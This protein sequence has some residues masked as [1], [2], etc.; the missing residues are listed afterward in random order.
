[1]VDISKL[2]KQGSRLD[3]YLSE[4]LKQQ[5]EIRDGEYPTH[6][7]LKL[8][9]IDALQWIGNEELQELSGTA[10]QR[11]DVS[12]CGAKPVVNQS[13]IPTT[14]HS[15]DTPRTMAPTILTIFM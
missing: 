2:K 11:N 14:K 9:T 13:Q 10:N 5:R 8:R 15:P 3:F 7:D 1:M 4:I 12:R 6:R